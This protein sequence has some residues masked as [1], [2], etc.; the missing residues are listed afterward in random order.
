L[1]SKLGELQQRFLQSF[2]AKENRF[3]LTGG[4]ALAGFHLG[5]RETHDLD[6]FTLMDAMEEG[7]AAVA[8]VAREMGCPLPK[9]RPP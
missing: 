7:S 6:L 2:F 1:H 5:H 8:E 4:A 3:F 9:F